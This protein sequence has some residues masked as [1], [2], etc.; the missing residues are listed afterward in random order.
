MKQIQNKTLL[1]LLG[2]LAITGYVII[3][4]LNRDEFRSYRLNL[5]QHVHRY[6]QGE[7]EPVSKP[8]SN[9]GLGSDSIETVEAMF[10]V[11][12]RGCPIGNASELKQFNMPKSGF[13][14]CM[15]VRNCSVT[16]YG[17]ESELRGRV[18]WHSLP[19]FN[20]KNQEHNPGGFAV[21]RNA[22]I[23]TTSG[24]IFNCRTSWFPGGCQAHQHVKVFDISK[25]PRTYVEGEVIVLM[26]YG[27][28]AYYHS[29]VE[30]FLRL[31]MVLPY[32]IKHN[33][34][35]VA[36]LANKN[37]EIPKMMELLLSICGIHSSRVMAVRKDQFL[38]AEKV[39]VPAATS[40]GKMRGAAGLLFRNI[41]TAHRN[42]TKGDDV[43]G[44]RIIVQN[45]K[46]NDDRKRNI[47][48]HAE[49][50]D[51][52]KNAYPTSI[53]A[54]FF[55]NESAEATLEMHAKANMIVAPHGAGLSHL[56]FSPPDTAV[57][58]IQPVTPENYINGCH[59]A[60]AEALGL[61][62]EQVLAEQTSK[63]MLA[64][65]SLVVS[66]CGKLYPQLGTR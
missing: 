59:R 61:R 19:D 57:V 17:T 58:E 51:A 39:I 15:D 11:A 16:Q 65:V 54:S 64:N 5:H 7:I 35:K 14:H 12:P 31:V 42:E 18:L 45:R 63:G 34:V 52:L 36:I 32:A 30:D 56:L 26:Q 66:A 44:H 13:S 62:Y 41:M 49:L 50:V 27:G 53:V 55:G 9:L 22:F 25:G 38:F 1:G 40:C 43:R 8:A 48:N 47:V 4:A 60:S 24:S 28:L 46:A 23:S 29:I 37:N 10:A 33:H 2:I 21:F 3:A 20:Y 6:F